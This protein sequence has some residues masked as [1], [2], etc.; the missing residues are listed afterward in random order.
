MKLDRGSRLRAIAAG[1][2]GASAGDDEGP[3]FVRGLAMGAFV[4]A[5]IAGSTLWSRW[6]ARGT[7]LATSGP[8][9]EPR[10]PA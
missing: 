5:A 3:S 10:D 9:E 2:R 8:A 4:G 7:R 1:L 6:R